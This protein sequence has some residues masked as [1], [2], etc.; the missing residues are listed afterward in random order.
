MDILLTRIV[1]SSIIVLA[2]CYINRSFFTTIIIKSHACITAAGGRE[3]RQRSSVNRC[4]LKGRYVE[5]I[6][7]VEFSN[8]ANCQTELR[9]GCNHPDRIDITTTC[10]QHQCKSSLSKRKKWLSSVNESNSVAAW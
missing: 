1:R 3:G 10:P 6:N 2:W 4:P 5:T 8:G 9:S 7:A